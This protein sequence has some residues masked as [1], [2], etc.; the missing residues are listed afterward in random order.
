[1]VD[2]MDDVMSVVEDVAKKEE[3]VVEG[4]YDVNQAFFIQSLC[5][6]ICANKII[7]TQTYCEY[8]IIASVSYL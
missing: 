6:F 5:V 3:E 4:H 2:V 8:T 7:G 1:M